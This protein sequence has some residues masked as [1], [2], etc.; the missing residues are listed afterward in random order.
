M[1][2]PLYLTASLPDALILAFTVVLV[3]ILKEF[4]A[5]SRQLIIMLNNAL[6]DALAILGI[7]AGGFLLNFIK[8]YDVLKIIITLTTLIVIIDL[9]SLP[10]LYFK[11]K[12]S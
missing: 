11:A 8:P 4:K 10:R 2:V 9:A 12:E 5:P 3:A 6:G 1:S 7:V